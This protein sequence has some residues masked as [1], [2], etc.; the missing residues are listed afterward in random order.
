MSEPL[1]S[2]HSSYRHPRCWASSLGDC[3][4]KISLEHYV[5][6]AVLG[7]LKAETLRGAAYTGGKS[8]I[9][10]QRANFGAKVLC[11]RHNSDL[12]PLDVNAQ[13]LFL[14]QRLFVS[15]INKVGFLPEDEQ[16]DISGDMLERWLL[17]SLITHTMSG[18]FTVQGTPVAPPNLE[19]VTQLVFDEIPWPARWG[20]WMKHRPEIVLNVFT[21]FDF[22]PIWMTKGRTLGGGRVTIGGLDFWISLFPPGSGDGGPFDGATYRPSGIVYK[23]PDNRKV[24][25]LHWRDGSLNPS[26]SYQARVSSNNEEGGSSS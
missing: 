12:S 2:E 9:A 26:I 13:I 21:G 14:A 7:V 23:F 4:T 24:I 6:N 25:C 5:S 17:K 11:H 10:I 19:R 18:I 15:E 1:P 20:L 22:T 3:H 16:I 8:G